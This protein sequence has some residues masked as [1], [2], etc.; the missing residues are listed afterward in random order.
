MAIVNVQACGHAQII[1]HNLRTQPIHFTDQQK[2]VK[3]VAHSWNQCFYIWWYQIF[4]N[5]SSAHIFEN[6]QNNMC[7]LQIRLVQFTDH[8]KKIARTKLSINKNTES[9]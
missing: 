3:Q 2:A 8:M 5:T 9:S 1:L 6:V 7:N 4:Y